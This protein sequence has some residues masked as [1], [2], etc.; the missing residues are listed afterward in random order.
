MLLILMQGVPSSGK[1]TIARKLQTALDNAIICSTDDFHPE[2]IFDGQNIGYYHAWNQWQTDFFLNSGKTVI[3]DNCNITNEHVKPYL[4]CARR[5]NAQII[6]R[7]CNGKPNWT[8]LHN[9]PREIV[10]R[11]RNTMEEL[12]LT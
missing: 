2:G 7:R 6:V 9:V 10:E 5:Y 11:M 4:D 12:M 3:V 1:S 8:S